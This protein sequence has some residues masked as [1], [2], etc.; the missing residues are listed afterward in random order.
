MSYTSDVIDDVVSSK[1]KTAVEDGEQP[2]YSIYDQD[3]VD[4]FLHPV[5]EKM[6][7][8]LGSPDNPLMAVKVTVMSPGTVIGVCI[9]HG[10]VDGQGE[11]LFVKAWSRV[12]RGLGLDG[13]YAPDN[14][15]SFGVGLKTDEEPLTDRYTLVTSRENNKETEKLMEILSTSAGRQFCIIPFTKAKL[16]EMKS[17]SSVDLPGGSFVSTN[18]VITATVIKAVIK[19]K[20]SQF[21][22]PVDS[23]EQ[24]V[25]WR[26]LN[27]RSF[28]IPQLTSTNTSN[29]TANMWLYLTVDQVMTMSVRDIALA[30]RARMKE[31]TKEKLM[32]EIQWRQN[33][34]TSGLKVQFKVNR[35]SFNVSSL[36]FPNVGVEDYDFGCKCGIFEFSLLNPIC[37]YMTPRPGQDGVNVW[38]SGQRQA[39]ETFAKTITSLSDI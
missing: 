17:R 21:E 11:L 15:R 19:T 5:K 37:V 1:F 27:L 9:Q 3:D 18:D 12:F 8:D 36:I 31:W 30:L 14:T 20:C 35:L 2:G 6:E 13:E 34:E 38:W 4:R 7:P 16:A 10:V 32:A 23:Q 24:V 22:I 25:V 28:S 26:G 39:L 33:A 29:A